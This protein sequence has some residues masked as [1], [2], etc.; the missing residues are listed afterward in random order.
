MSDYV[1]VL[2]SGEELP[3]AITS[4]RGVRNITLRPK[5]FPTR[6][7][8]IS[9][10]WLVSDKS[11]IKFLESKQSWV[12][13]IFQKSPCK[14]VLQDGDEIEFLG[15][16]IILKHNSD[17]RSNK[18]SDDGAILFVGGAPDMFQRRVRDFLKAQLLYEIK[19]IMRTVPKE[20]LP[21]RIALRDTVSRWGSCSTSGTMSFSWR[22]A[23]APYDVMRYVVMHE[24]AHTKHMNHSPE[25]W[26][27]VRELYGGRVEWAKRWLVQNGAS[28]HQYC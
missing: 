10:P 4:R 26:A 12:Q 6:M 9:K 24:L 2:S 1:F 22:L 16:K 20:F 3:V 11:A 7:I 5:V 13:S 21:R 28:L 8:C 27:T 19:D 25:F 15:R 17:L 23:F 18:L 14:I